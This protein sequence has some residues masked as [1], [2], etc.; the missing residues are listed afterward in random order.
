MVASG[1]SD[2]PE[3][4]NTFFELLSSIFMTFVDFISSY[5][6]KPVT[7]ISWSSDTRFETP[8]HSSTNRDETGFCYSFI[9]LN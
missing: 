7:L 5:L 4:T 8:Y 6:N 9:Y 1:N 2:F 3:T